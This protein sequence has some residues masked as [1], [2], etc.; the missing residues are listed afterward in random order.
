MADLMR[1]DDLRKISNDA[2]M[3]KAQEYLARAKRQEEEQKTMRELFMKEEDVPPEAVERVNNAVRRAAEQGLHEV[4]VFSFP[5][6]YCND[7]GRRINSNEPDWPD[8][9]E[10]HA[11][12]AYAYFEKELRPLGYKVRVEILD[13]PSGIPGNVGLFL[14]W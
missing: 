6:S 11:K 4:Q 14:S 10:G 1:P 8:S 7:R 2:E 12:K 5:A 13:Y 9:L 3:K